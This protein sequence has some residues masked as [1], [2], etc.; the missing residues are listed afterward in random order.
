MGLQ[1]IAFM[2]S[3]L[4]GFAG[5]N[6][7]DEL[8]ARWLQY[9]VFNPIYRPH[10]GENVPSEP[11]YRSEKAKNL[12]KKAIELRYALLPYNYN[13]VFENHKNGTPLMRPLFFEEP[14]NQNFTRIILL[15]FGAKIS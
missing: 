7:D 13:L 9:G 5:K 14:E 1:G 3:D 2:H 8:Y 10:T 4:G 12:A 15:I 11:I 6:E